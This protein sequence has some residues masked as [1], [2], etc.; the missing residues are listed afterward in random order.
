MPWMT[1][2]LC[3]HL[4]AAPAPAADGGPLERFA[5]RY[6]G[7]LEAHVR[8]RGVDY[9][10]LARDPRLPEL[11]RL[12]AEMDP[13]ALPPEA[14]KAFLI[15]AYN[16]TVL[17]AV[18]ERLPLAS[19]LDHEDFFTGARHAVAGRRLTLDG[20]E[21]G[22]LYTE[23]PDAR[24]HFAL[25]CAARGCPA[26]EARSYSASVGAEGLDARLGHVTRRALADPVLVAVDGTTV[27]LSRIFEWYAGDFGASREA[28]LAWINRHRDAPLPDGARVAYTD[29]DWRLNDVTEY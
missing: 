12:V 20:L 23:F 29:Y 7:L 18:A 13:D 5:D 19:V 17:A 22:W 28:L 9:T 10:A 27:R 3:L 2:L 24:L 1:L 25:V 15:D 14:R 11:R 16:L 21:K 6:D 8:R 26:L 4:A